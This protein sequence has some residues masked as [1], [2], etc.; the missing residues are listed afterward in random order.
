MTNTVV[1]LLNTPQENGLC[2]NQTDNSTLGERYIT[3]SRGLALLARTRCICYIRPQVDSC[4]SLTQHILV[5]L[6]ACRRSKHMLQ[7]C[8]VQ[9]V[10][11][12]TQTLQISEQHFVVTGKNALCLMRHAL[13]AGLFQLWYLLP[14]CSCH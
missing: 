11:Q 7:P 14:C 1:T 4:A 2:F 3:C 5:I 6:R 8:I 12:L 10:Q 9:L 13:K